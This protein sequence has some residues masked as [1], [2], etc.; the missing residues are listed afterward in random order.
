MCSLALTRRSSSRFHSLRAKAWHRSALRSALCSVLLTAVSDERMFAVAAQ[1]PLAGFKTSLLKNLKLMFKELGKPSACCHCRAN[2]TALCM[3]FVGH[4][5]PSKADRWDSAV[6]AMFGAVGSAKGEG[7]QLTVDWKSELLFVCLFGLIDCCALQT[8]S[9]RAFATQACVASPCF[10]RVGSTAK[11]S[12][13]W[14]SARAAV[15]RALSTSCVCPSAVL[16]T[17]IPPSARLSV[18]ITPSMYS[19][20]CCAL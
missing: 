2:L 18:D 3:A 16:A 4:I 1:R 11:T 5:E 15:V 12:R 6:D 13:E 19:S 7:K 20:I 10:A 14:A 9:S 17:S 8:A